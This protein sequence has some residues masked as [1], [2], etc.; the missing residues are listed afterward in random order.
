[1]NISR[2]ESRDGG[3]FS[4]TAANTVGAVTHTARLNIYGKAVV[5]F[6]LVCMKAIRLH[7]QRIAQ[8]QNEMNASSH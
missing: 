2:V 1:V 4:C 6:L 5:L 8:S 3:S 7:E